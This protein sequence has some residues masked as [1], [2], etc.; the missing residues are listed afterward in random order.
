M[1]KVYWY[2]TAYAKKHGLVFLSSIIFAIAIFS[3]IIPSLAATVENKQKHYIGIIGDFTLDT[4]P[5][6]IT[7]KLS[8]GLTKIEPD[9]T[10]IPLLSE[11]WT[12]E[13][14]GKTYRFI[15]KKNVYWT[16]GTELQT[17]DIKYSFSDVE[18]IITPNDI[19]FKLPD[20]FAPFPAAVATP[21][22]KKET[23][24]YRLFLKRPTIVGIGPYKLI[25]YKKKANRISE[26][27]LEGQQERYV[28]RFYL[29]EKDAVTAFKHGEVDTLPNLSQTFDLTE[30]K[31]VTITKQLDTQKY[32]A[33]FFN[34]NMPLFTK[35]IRQALSYA[36]EKPVDDSR[37]LG[38]INPQSWAY[39]PAGKTYDK[40]IPRSIERILDEVPQEPIQLELTTTSLYQ[41]DAQSIK[42]QWE[43]LGQQAY[44]ACQTTTSITDK[45]VCDNVKI[46]VNLRIT[47]FPDTSNFQ[48]LLIGQESP[49]DPDQYSLWHSDQSTNFS[50]YKNTR[51]DNLLE[52]GRKTNN[53]QERKEIYQEFQQFFLEDAPA[54]FL[55]HLDNYTITR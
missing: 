2:L 38:P 33:V 7:S 12:L 46:T 34:I 23:E 20:T 1:R 35:N 5:I 45:T 39:L 24:T 32:L 25:D 41:A 6:E 8:A 27:T 18:T 52:K 53:T 50:R 51:I 48:L 4:L 54:I 42:E 22:L 15:L 17:N 55:R 21:I 40:D 43:D 37:A 49:S 3:F 47:N 19:V 13:Q 14:D 9:G 26:V 16:D 11:R 29:T 30:W 28:Y 31:T 10:V 36:L 44:T